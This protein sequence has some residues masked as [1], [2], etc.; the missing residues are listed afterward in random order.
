MAPSIAA[1]SA[2]RPLAA[3]PSCGP[4]RERVTLEALALYGRNFWALVL[5]CAI[6]VLPATLLAAGAVRFGVAALSR[7][8]VAEPLSHSEQIQEKQRELLEKPPADEEVRTERVRQLGREALEGRAA[9][10]GHHILDNVGPIAVETA[11]FVLFLLAGLFLA[12]AAAVPLVLELCHGRSA[13][14]AHAWAAAG[15]RIGAV[16]LTALS[17]SL[18]VAL[19]ALFFVIPGFVLAV[20]FSLAPPLVVLEGLRGRAALERSWR[21][22][23]GN[24]GQALWA[25]I[26]IVAFSAMASAGALLLPPG[27][28]RPVVSALICALLYPLP[29]TGLILIYRDARK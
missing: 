1:R 9:F 8:E 10:D 17:S 23:E 5:T 7:D 19:G 21:L 12:H 18:L 14:P 24:W 6:A 20:G 2:P 28:W 15:S 11:A 4:H 13:G 22:L 25:W 26:L 16:L 3:S 29:L 27:P